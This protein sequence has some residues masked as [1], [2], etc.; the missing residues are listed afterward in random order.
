MRPRRHRR[1]ALHCTLGL[2][3]M[4]SSGAIAQWSSDPA[5]PLRVGYAGVTFSERH[6]IVGANDGAVWA[7]WQDNICVGAVRLQRVSLRGM[8][9][10]PD[11]LLAQ[12]DPTCGFHLPPVL[13][14]T[15]G[16]T[17]VSR[18]RVGL[19]S[20]PVQSFDAGGALTW[21]S[22]FMTSEVFT[23]GGAARL[24]SDDV[25]IVSH[26]QSTIRADRV[27][28]Q[29]APVWASPAIFDNLSGSNMRV[30]AV[31]PE[32]GGGAYIFWDASPFPYTRLIRVQRLDADGLPAWEAPIRLN[33]S[34]PDITSS[35]HTDPVA[36]ADGQGGA[37]LMFTEGFETGFTPAP[38]RMQRIAPDGS[39]A[40]PLEGHV[41]S[42]GADRQFDPIVEPDDAT[43][44]LIV[45][46]RN[47]L[48]DDQTINAQRISLG[49]DRLWGDAGVAIHPIERFGSS[50]DAVWRDGRL[51][52]VIGGEGGAVMR[53]VDG[54]GKLDPVALQL[55]SAEQVSDVR[56]VASGD[57]IVVIW[58]RD[59]PG[60]DDDAIVAQRVNPSGRLGDPACNAG[61]LAS[62]FGSLDFSDVVAFLSAFASMDP[63]A[64]LAP[65]A[66]T[67][68]FS[69]VV[70]FLGAFAGGCP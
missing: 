51:S 67:L 24:A 25:M 68:D 3:S 63:L 42:L 16:S 66:G 48:L 55:S 19:D 26:A 6:N 37:V 7:A 62:P 20:Y 2:L 22:G 65:P 43:G 61:D 15:N 70:A 47:G 29:G 54:A 17:I 4:A 40:F 1:F 36:V 21:P 60:D 23:L 50:F 38:L 59:R 58:Y 10:S 34:P 8:L 31:V 11:G 64:D 12:E 28:P 30:F 27:D 44:D 33:G 69:D 45:S 49:G 53:R 57:G 56:S 18:A 41:V 13:V 52:V 46:W 35:R 5:T 39:L 14:T 32:P 9:L